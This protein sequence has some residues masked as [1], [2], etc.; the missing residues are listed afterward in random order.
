[1]KIKDNLI[2][3]LICFVAVSLYRGCDYKKQLI[4][5]Q[6]E[7]LELIEYQSDMS[8]KINEKGEEIAEQKA[9]YLDEKAKNESLFERIKK[10]ESTISNYTVSTETVIERV[11][12]PIMKTDTIR[13]NGEQFERHYF[14]YTEPYFSFSGHADKHSVF[15]DTLFVPSKMT[16]SHKWTKKN[17]LSKKQYVIQSSIDNP[18]VNISGMSNYTFVEEKKWHEKRGF[19]LITG[20]IIGALAN[21]M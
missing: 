10:L 4:G 20:F 18:Y 2:L 21:Q 6:K 1:M 14:D 15:I 19:L 16:L 17:I 7:V 3:V 11:L 5:S 8:I 13:E 12:V 9:L